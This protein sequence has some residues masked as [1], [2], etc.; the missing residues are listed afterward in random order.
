M[1]GYIFEKYINQKQMGA[2]YTKED[3]TEY[4]GKNTILPFVLERARANC[5]V[6]FERPESEVWRLLSEDPDRYIYPAVLRGVDLPLPPGDR[7]RGGRRGA[8]RR[9]EPTRR[10]AFAL[11]TETWREHV[12]RRTRCLDLRARLAAGEVTA[13]NDL[14]TYNLDIRRFTQDVIENCEGSDLL[15]ALWDALSTVTILA[16]SH[17]PVRHTS[18]GPLEGHLAVGAVALQQEREDRILADVLGDLLWVVRPHLLL[19]DVLLEDVAED[20]GVDLVV[21]A[22]RALVQVPRCTVEEVEHA[23]EGGVRDLDRRA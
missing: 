4:I 18:L 19:V 14:I 5:K 15:R 2:Y 9:L 21:R 23:L 17:I 6:A 10:P 7:R 1:L 20:V 22:Q 12:A 16:L 8:A 11:P 3:I 13:V